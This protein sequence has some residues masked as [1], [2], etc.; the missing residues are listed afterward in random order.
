MFGNVFITKT[1][2]LHTASQNCLS[3]GLV[4]QP[5]LSL[6]PSD[7]TLGLSEELDRIE[8]QGLYG[9]NDYDGVKALTA[10]EDSWLDR[11]YFLRRKR[12]RKRSLPVDGGLGG[13]RRC[14]DNMQRWIAADV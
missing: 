14:W 7:M 12:R 10:E 4:C 2:Q 6:F 1:N 11:D 5:H 3:H 9:N 13:E 8:M